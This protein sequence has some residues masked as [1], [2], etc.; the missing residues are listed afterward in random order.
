MVAMS[1]S[2]Y[3]QFVEKY[4]P[5]RFEDV[6]GQQTAVDTLKRHVETRN[7]SSILAAGPF[8]T[9]KTSLMRIFS[10]AMSCEAASPS[11]CGHCD[12]CKVF[13]SKHF[14]DALYHHYEFNGSEHREHERGKLAANLNN[15]HINYRYGIFVD[16]VHGLHP[17]AADALL[18]AVEQPRPG[19]FYMFATTE[20]DAVRPALRSRCIELELHPLSEAHSYDLLTRICDAEGIIWDRAALEMLVVAGRGSA[21]DLVK[22]L[23]LT[24]QQGPLTV[25]L[26]TNA[27]SLGWVTHILSYFDALLSGDVLEQEDALVRWQAPARRKAEAVRNFLVYLHNFEVLNRARVIEPAFH[28]VTEDQR[29][30]I[31]G[32]LLPRA[33]ASNMDLDE[34]LLELAERW[35]LDLGTIPDEPSLL[36]RLRKFHRLVNPPSLEPAPANEHVPSAIVTPTKRPK[37]LRSVRSFSP[38][39]T[40]AGPETKEYLS[41]AQAEAI[42]DAASF[43]PQRYGLLFNTHLHLDHAEMGAS[44]AGEIADLISRLTHQLGMRLPKWSGDEAHWLYLNAASGAGP[45]TDLIMHVPVSAQARVEEWFT[46][47]IGKWRGAGPAESDKWWLAIDDSRATRARVQRHWRLVRRLWRGVDPLREHWT[48]PDQERRG[49]LADLLRVPRKDRWSVGASALRRF[50]TSGT[51]GPAARAA[52][53]ANKMKL[54]SAFADCAWSSIDAGWELHEAKERRDEVTRRGQQSEYLNERFPQGGDV[55]ETRQR[56]QA[57]A[58]MESSWPDDPRQRRRE[59]NEWQWWQVPT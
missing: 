38:F 54:L 47:V 27:L 52:S 10:N 31:V 22:L 51:I 37:R 2:N 28:Q 56:E 21:R 25:A 18:K 13:R 17:T 15:E 34:Y 29:A 8:G 49:L 14:S 48:T 50:S 45:V 32:R 6:V 40:L 55:L 43:L 33:T 19:T 39:P 7:N 30:G 53:Q 11:P 24:S 59:S 42:Y 20:P 4:R 16:E 1:D 12:I 44:T 58:E 5:R 26:L 35:R 36:I 41:L 46:D 3:T 9:G 57:I 23:D